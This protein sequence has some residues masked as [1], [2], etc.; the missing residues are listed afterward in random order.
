MLNCF[1]ERIQKENERKAQELAQ[2]L[3]EQEQKK[4]LEEQQQTDAEE[5]NLPRQM[6]TTEGYQAETVKGE[7]VEPAAAWIRFE[8][9]LTTEQ[10]YKLKEFF[11]EN[12]IEFRAI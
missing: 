2:Q 8:A 10:A 6:E 4:K 3:A 11:E 5:G 9:K 12:K 1:A 7:E